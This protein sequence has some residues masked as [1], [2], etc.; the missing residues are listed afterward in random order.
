MNNALL[1]EAKK[2]EV[3]ERK[4]LWEVLSPTIIELRDNKNFTFQ[5][6]AD[7]LIIKGV[8]KATTASVYQTYKKY[9]EDK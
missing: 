7:W 2:E 6:I 5:Q 3:K 1:E 4:G 9:K 8:K